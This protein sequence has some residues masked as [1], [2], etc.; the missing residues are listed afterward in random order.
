MTTPTTGKADLCPV[1]SPNSFI[2]LWSIFCPQD[3]GV[4]TRH[5][6]RRRPQL[7]QAFQLPERVQADRWGGKTDSCWC[8]SAALKDDQ[9]LFC[10]SKCDFICFAR[11]S[12]SVTTT[13]WRWSWKP[14][15]STK[16]REK[17]R[18][19]CLE[20]Q[21]RHPPK[22]RLRSK[23]Q[24]HVLYTASTI[25]SHIGAFCIRVKLFDRIAFWFNFS[26]FK[27]ER[28]INLTFWSQFS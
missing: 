2:R 3:R 27:T 14:I 16:H 15:R 17:G 23:V 11:L 5:A 10:Y 24:W 4:R 6:G 18:R 21:T 22:N 19:L 9:Q 28:I 20:Q 26:Y 1:W 12:A 7:S 13:L 8:W 25:Y